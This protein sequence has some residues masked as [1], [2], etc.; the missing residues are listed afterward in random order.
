MRTRGLRLLHLIACVASVGVACQQHTSA[1]APSPGT[2]I[3]EAEIDSAHVSSA[4]EL[5]Q[6][7][8]P[9]FLVSRGNLTLDP[10]EPPSQVH[11]YLDNQ[12]Y[13]DVSSLRG[14]LIGTIES[15]RYYTGSEAQYKF[16]VNNAAG[17]IAV[18]TKH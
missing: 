14:I 13:G 4:Y 8:R 18:T 10:R 9:Q 5:I 3:T 12:L 11:V 6:K 2:I 17:V 16:G 1:G 15:I 7:L